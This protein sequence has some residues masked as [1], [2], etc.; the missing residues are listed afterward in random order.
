MVCLCPPR[1]E[2]LLE[3]DGYD[4]SKC[5]AIEDLEEENQGPGKDTREYYSIS[6][7]VTLE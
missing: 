2:F 6:V 4:S 3:T 5:Y 1:N 7:E